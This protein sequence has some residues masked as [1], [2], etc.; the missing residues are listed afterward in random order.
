VKQESIIKGI[1]KIEEKNGQLPKMNTT[2]DYTDEELRAIGDAEGF[3]KTNGIAVDRYAAQNF[4]AL[5]D[6]IV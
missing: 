3:S 1:K 2:T 5:I 6:R 4:K